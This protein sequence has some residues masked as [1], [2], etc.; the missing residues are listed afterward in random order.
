MKD[1]ARITHVYRDLPL[2]F[3]DKIRSV[4]ALP[5][6]MCEFDIILGIDWL[7]AHR[8]TIDC[9]S[10]RL[11]FG[12]INAP[13]FIY[14]GSLPGKSMKIISALK[15][16]TLL[17]HGCEGFLAT[18]HDT[19]SDVSSIHDQPIVSEF[20]DV[21][22]EE[23]PGIPPIRDVE[24]NIELI[25]GAEPISKAPYRMAP[26][27]LKELKDQLHRSCWSEIT[28]RN[29]YP[30]P[31]IDDLFDQL[32]GAKHFSKIDLRSGYHQ[33]RV[34][35][36]DISKTAFRTRYG[37]YEFLV[38][39][40]GL[41]NAPAVFM[42]LM[43]RVF[44]EF[45]DKF[46]IVFIDDI[47]VF[48]KSK[49]EHEEHLRTVLQILRQEKLYA[50]FSKC[51]FWLSKV[52]FLGHIVSAEGITM[53][54]AKVEAITKWP[55]PTSVTEVRSFLGLAGYYRRFVEGFSRL[56]LPLTKLMRKGE[57]FVWNEEREKSFE[58]LKQRLV[59]S[60]ILT[61]PSG[62]G[63]FQIYS[64]ASK[65]GLGC[66]LMQHGKVIAYASRQLKPYE[67]NYPTH[68]LEL[69]AVVFAL[70]IWRHYLY[71][72]S[73]DI[74]TDHKS[75]KYIFTQRELN[76]RQRRWLELLKDY[77]TNIQYHPGKANVVADAL[78]RKS[79]MIAGIKVEEEIIR[80]LER[81]DIE[82]CVRGQSGFWASL[83]TEFHVDDDGILWQGTKLCIP[84]DPTLR[85]AL[86]AEA[87]SSS[88]S[89]HPGST[90]M[91]HDLKQHF[92]WSGMKRDVATF[93]S[94][95]LICQQVKIE[96]Q[97]ASGLLQP[98]EIPVW[99]WDEISM[100]FV[101]G[102]PRTQRKH[103]AIWVVV[104]R[105]TKSAHF[106]PIRK[107]Y[108]VYRKLGEPGSSYTTCQPETDDSRSD[109]DR[110]AV[111]AAVDAC[112]PQI[113][114]RFCDESALVLYLWVVSPPVHYFHILLEASNKAEIPFVR[115]GSSQLIGVY[116]FEGDALAC[117]S[118]RG[119]AK[120]RLKRE[121]HSICQ[122]ASEN[123]TDLQMVAQVADAAR[124]LEILRDRDDYDR[125]ERSDKRHKSG[126]RYQ[127]ATQQNS[128]RG[129]DQKNDRQGSDR[130]GGGGNY[131]NN[132]NNNYSR[133][134]NRS[135]L[136]RY[137]LYLLYDMN[138]TSRHGNRNSGAG[139][140]QRNRGQQSHRSTNSGKSFEI[141]SLFSICLKVHV[142]RSIIESGSQQSRVPSEGY[143]HPVCNTCGRRHPGECRRAAGTCFKCGQAGHL[144]RDCKKNTGA[145][146]SGH[147]DK[148]PDASGRV[149]ALTQD[150][151]ANTSG[152]ITGA[153]FIFGRAVFVLFDTGATHSV[154]STKF[155]SCFTMT[156]IL[157]DHVL[158]ISTP[159][160]DSA[161]ITHVYRDLPLQF[162][163]KIRSV[164][165][166][167]LDM[168]EFDI[169]L[170]ID[171]LAAHRATIDC[172]SRRVI[173][174]D[175]HAP[176][177]I[178]HGSLP[179]KSMKI[180]S[181]L[182]ART[183]LSHGC[184]GFL[185]TIH[186]TTSD[187]SSIHDQSIV[188]EF[189]DVFPEELP[190]IPP[191]RDVEFNIE[192]IPGAE[193]ISKAPYRMAPIELKE[194][195][196]QLQELLE[197]GF[198]RP[199]V[200]PW[201][202]PVLF[203]KK[204]DGSMRLCIDYRELNKITIRNRYPLPRIDDLF[205]Q[206][207]G[208]KHFS[209]ID[210]RS[211]YHQLRVKEQDISKT[212]FRTRYGHYEFLVMPFGL[213]NAPAVFMDLMNR[214][215]HEFLDKFVIVFIDDIL[216]FSK[217]KEEHEEHLRTV[218]QILRQE[219]LYAKFSKCEFWLSKVAF[220]GHIVSAEGITMDPAKV[221][222]IT[223]WPRPTSVTEVRSFLGLAGYYR[224][225]VEGFSRLA[226]PL[227]KLM[228]K[229]E[230]FV[231]N[232]EREKSFEELKQRLVS[233]PILT[234]PSGSGGFQIYS[235][236]SK[237]GLGCV[238]MQHG[239]VIAYA[240]RQLKPYEVNYPTHDLEL[241][242][243]VFALKIWRHYLYGE[244]CDIFTDHKSLK[245]IF[246]QRELNM[247]QRRW[248]E[249]LKDYDTNIQYHPG[250]ANV[251]AD[252][253]SRKSG[254]IAGIKVEEEIICDLERLDIELCVR[255]QNGFWAS[256]R[257]EPNLISQIKAA[258]KDDGEIWAIIQNIDQQTE[259]RVDD[260][261]ILWQG[262]KLCVPEDPTLREALMT[263]AHS[264]PFSIHPGSTKMYH[265][266][267]QHF[268]WSGMKRDVATFMSKYLIC[269]QVKIEHQRASGLLQP[270]EI[271]I[272]KWDEIS[273]DF[274]TGLPQTQRKHDSIWVVVDRLTKSAHFLPIHKDYPISKLA[275]MFQ[276]EI[277]RLH[278]TPSAIVSD[279]DPHFMSRFW[280]GL[281]KAWG[282]RL[283]FST[284]FHPETD[285]QS[286][287]TIQTLEDMLHSCALEWT[288]NWNDYICLVE[289]AYNNSWH[290]SIKC[291]P[292]E[293]LYGRK[294]RAPICWDQV[295]ERIL[296]GPEMIEV[297]NEGAVA[298]E[299]LKELRLV[300]RVRRQASRA[301]EF[302]REN[303]FLERTFAILDR[304]EGYKYHPLHVVSYPFDQIREDL[305]YTEEPESILDR[306]DRMVNTRT[307]AELAAAIQAAVDAML[308]QIRE[309]VR[310]E[311]RTGAVTSGSNPP[312]VTIHTWL[313]RFNK[314][315]PRSFE[316]AV[317]P[318][319]A[320]N[321]IS[322]MEKIFDVMDCNDAFKTRLAVYKFEGDALAWWKAYKQ[323]K[324]GDVWV[325]TL[326]WAAF[327]ELFFLQFFPRAEQERLKREYHS[328]RQRASENSTEYMQ[329]F[330]RLAGFLGQAAGTA[331]EQAKNFR[332][333]LHKSI[334]DHVM[335]I[336]FTDVAQVA[337]AARNLEILRDRDDY[338]RSERSD[339]R[340]K[341]GDRYQ[342]A[343]QQN[344]Y[345]G[346]DQKNDRQ[347][348]DRQ[349][350]GGNY[351]NNNNNNYSR[352]NNMNSGA[353]RDQRNRGQQSHRSTNSGSQQSR[354][355]S[356]GYTH[357]VCNTCGRRHPGEC[358]RAAGTCFK[359]GQAGH[360]Q[361][362]C[363][364]NTGASSSGHADK[365]PDAS[366]RVFALTQDQAANTSGT[367][368][369]ALFIFGRAVFV[370]FDTGATHS[371]IS[372][373]FASCF[374]MTPILLDHV[375]CISTPM[376]DSARITHVY[377]DL[378]LQ[379]DDK[380]RSVN[381]LPLDMCEF[382][383]ILG[384]DWLAAHR[385]TIDAFPFV[386]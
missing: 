331:E 86:M 6:D 267:K 206:L 299:R 166:L 313:E 256:L 240:S 309:Q 224:R 130:Q 34:K 253:L 272:W 89:I 153:L 181:A 239:K 106:L 109:A 374:T 377:R 285:G 94:K 88:F 177:F 303:M 190:G 29:R 221:E 296:E 215:F 82:L 9:H 159:M 186:D 284:A 262:T 128:Y 200:S 187:V 248:L 81:L 193:P 60:P 100:D 205:D 145:S 121:Y 68:D 227:T 161:R 26:I 311:Y 12:D 163:D 220:L 365:K 119:R 289:F 8:A 50:K 77:D 71:G 126:D 342:S 183:L 189:Q 260:D 286:E 242:A 188:S 1:S 294:C 118:S 280:K 7:V 236:A 314:Q 47:L 67:V 19:T 84:E 104:D 154:I 24:F 259:F 107:D 144:Q 358:R 160:K 175:I 179:G 279:K 33:L 194:L 329:R 108:P 213:T 142:S 246:T 59:S 17:S 251:V 36:Q 308:P 63:G 210:L 83:R 115:E 79:G 316:K 122:R 14:H 114:I 380:I 209:K 337:D 116:K 96:H 78:S 295:G 328:I 46:V 371:V 134:N 42:D 335:C 4:N 146:S 178:Y 23:L 291:A 270:L 85:E 343:T 381:A 338:D 369:G 257:V 231:W 332:W 340:H 367:I 229:G 87:H 281:Q 378:P 317:A 73:C 41:T 354:V 288:G 51:E 171:W 238:L 208:A 3:D 255:G 197:R 151:A 226:L 232:E 123:S 326:T 172:H 312:L 66:V 333:G 301:L 360:L 49:E 379:F 102:L 300:R 55:R 69:A 98:L 373:K 320:E 185:A 117:F 356:K 103:D 43:N 222:A 344:S 155:A 254:M 111:H 191:I 184:E 95:C 32:Q 149:F 273:M 136:N 310:E 174:G 266:L 91:Y 39:P 158:C 11:I 61:L 13:E 207:Q 56:A 62:S 52:A 353:G 35:E 247:R 15:A 382:D 141:T 306:Q 27:E 182:K 65:K 366:G 293:M 252:A 133:D 244:S 277:V 265:D 165:A 298:R 20:Q 137:R 124:N 357:P 283:K 361:R 25:P 235:D 318:V 70:K 355:P 30:L 40:F 37:H 129:H 120:E 54:P 346:H 219:K 263:E 349:G 261:G 325:L 57:K 31:R 307:D 214:V 228:R 274:V 72:E 147:A 345:R 2:Q 131:R 16:R 324:G 217:S 362:D 385:A 334:L 212:A 347:G 323:A 271:P 330:L 28:I 319:D 10:R 351:R 80:D 304:V 352:D 290:A 203:V 359:C 258:Q 297:T 21:F 148:K 275:E 90:K 321:W 164:N 302:Q 92:W 315:K 58:E 341:S 245:Y 176:E 249:L 292:F 202:A 97:R 139:R 339:K 5:L 45:L 157:L 372:T 384:I 76:M 132:N 376:K 363:K 250:K 305:S 38:M 113:A 156:P 216:V 350:G 48:S 264:S 327:K 168:C 18:I 375:L 201:G 140:D 196:D 336:Q 22:P 243:V 230:K 223:K 110:W 211:G 180:I 53:D 234:L 386:L 152:T 170:G 195:K 278:G 348:S 138:L 204:K 167:P 322:H 64:D 173:F 169:I 44:H 75:L 162:D 192:L 101:T 150:Q 364:K 241:A 282:T 276:Q 99:K 135:N 127:S 268:W 74:F 370:L 287:R 368:T 218:L 125:S 269:Q 383:I 93:V 198:I 199:S 112:I 105:L 143:T 237:K 233:S 225:F